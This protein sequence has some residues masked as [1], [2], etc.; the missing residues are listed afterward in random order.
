[1]CS[2]KNTKNFKDKNNKEV[3]VIIPKECDGKPD[4]VDF[5]SKI[6]IFLIVLIGV[7]SILYNVLL[8]D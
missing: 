3:K 4:T 6:I 8:K 2:C 5:I 7:F 1:M